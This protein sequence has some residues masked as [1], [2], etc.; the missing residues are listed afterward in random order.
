MTAVRRLGVALIGVMVL[1]AACASSPT[2]QPQAWPGALWTKSGAIV[3]PLIIDAAAG[4]SQCGDWRSA[5]FLTLGWPLGHRALSAT[6]A[7]Q[8]VR[9]LGGVIDPANLRSHLDLHASLPPDARPTGYF[10]GEAQLYLAHSD[11]DVAIYMVEGN[12][13]ERWPRSD[14]MTTCS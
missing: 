11:E 5:T 4:P 13:V 1:G 12:T 9:D 2:Q 3:S 8:Y 10:E 14:P 6:Q 7:R